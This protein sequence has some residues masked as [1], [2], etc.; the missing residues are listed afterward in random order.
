MH[1]TFS[2]LNIQLLYEKTHRQCADIYTKGFENSQKWIDAC[3]LVGVVDRHHLTELLRQF[4]EHEKERGEE[5]MPPESAT[6]SADLTGSKFPTFAAPASRRGVTTNTVTSDLQGDTQSQPHKLTKTQTNKV[7][8]WW[9]EPPKTEL[10]G[11]NVIKEDADLSGLPNTF[12]EAGTA[13]RKPAQR[14]RNYSTS[15]PSTRKSS[16]MK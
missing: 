15:P 1:E 3:L 4:T 16:G 5:G 13:S 9:P 11:G 10:L 14:R 6:N 12:Q 2:S 8:P 7:E